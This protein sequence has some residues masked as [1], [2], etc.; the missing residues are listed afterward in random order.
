[1]HY[2]N[3]KTG[4]TYLIIKVNALRISSAS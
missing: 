2:L 3:G 4:A 1:M